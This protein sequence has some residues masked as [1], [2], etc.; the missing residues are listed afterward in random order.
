MK[1]ESEDMVR[2]EEEL[3][4]QAAQQGDTGL[5]GS[6]RGRR[7]ETGITNVY[8]ASGPTTPQGDAKLQPMGTLGQGDRGPE[9]YQDSGGSEIISNER[10]TQGKSG[11]S[12]P[13]LAGLRVAAIVTDGFEEVELVE[14]LDTLQKA[15]ARVEV[16]A[17]RPGTVQAFR[18]LDR[19]RTVPV[20]RLLHDARPEDYDALLLPGGALNADALRVLPEVQSFVH[21]FQDAGKP[22]AVICHAPWILVSADLVRGRRL[23]SY[24]TIQDDIRNAGGEWFDQEVVEDGNWVTSR[25]PRDIPAFNRAML[26]LF[27][28]VP[29]I[30][31]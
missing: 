26:R 12:T 19:G 16:I 17:P 15:G 4:Q 25:Q 27:A 21:H 5:P 11:A 30:H 28:R 22:M 6:G 1:R 3:A 24:H 9:G 29:A 13:D 31:G 18:H 10:F 2:R 14:P 23:T 7:D 20:D 8:P